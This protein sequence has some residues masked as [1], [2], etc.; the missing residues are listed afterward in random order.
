MFFDPNAM[1]ASMSLGVP[2]SQPSSTPEGLGLFA[3]I[4]EANPPVVYPADDR[5]PDS[6]QAQ[7]SQ[8]VNQLLRLAE[9]NGR[10][11]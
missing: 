11:Q 2:H 4:A 8:N 9:N 1:F 6:T 3:G 7:D 10:R 5:V